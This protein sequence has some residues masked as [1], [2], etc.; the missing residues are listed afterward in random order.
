MNDSRL[1]ARSV[2]VLATGLDSP[3]GLA[4]GPDGLLYVAEAGCAGSSTTVDDCRQVQAPIGPYRGGMTARI[5]RV[6]PDGH[7]VTFSEGLPSSQPVG[8]SGGPTGVADVVCVRG[9][10]YALVAGGGCSHGL[11]GTVNGIY[12]VLRDG[13][14]RLIADLG[15]YRA[16]TSVAHPDPNDD[17]YDGTWYSMTE[18]DD[19][20]FV[21]EP[22]HGEVVRV[23]LD[24]SISRLVD[25]SASQGHLV[26][27]AI[28]YS[29]GDNAFFLGN[30]GRLP[31]EPGS[32]RILKISRR[33][34]IEEWAS[35]LTMVLGL[36][37]DPLGRLYA[38]EN[39]TCDSP[40]RPTPG[41]GRVVR[42]NEDRTIEP[43][44]EGLTFPTGMTFGPDGMLYVSAWGFGPAGGGSILRISL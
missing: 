44:V 13:S 32:A 37:F 40:C 1:G 15:S 27:T 20:L 26:P 22:N 42:L 35:G 28:A 5:S 9:N 21:V 4:F 12:R 31:A 3:R 38:L 10:L 16:S 36:A 19:N 14:T 29:S 18:A 43:L 11:K 2:T 24:G 25:V 33:G 7:R 8:G 6:S 23:G 17:E 41:T 34:R 39:S 30:L